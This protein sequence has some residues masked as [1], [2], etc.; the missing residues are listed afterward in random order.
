MYVN[1]VGYNSKYTQNVFNCDESDRVVKYFFRPNRSLK[2]GE[3]VELL[4]NY[5]DSY[6]RSR[7]RKGYGWRNLHEGL[8]GDCCLSQ[9]IQRNFVDRADVEEIIHAESSV[10]KLSTYINF[11]NDKVW[12]PLVNKIET[13]LSNSDCVGVLS[14]NEWTAAVRIQWLTNAFR[15]KVMKY[16]ACTTQDNLLNQL[17]IY[18]MTTT[19]DKIQSRAVD[20]NVFDE[21][22][23]LDDKGKSVKDAI[24]NELIEEVGFYLQKD[25]PMLLDSSVYCPVAVRL[26][27]K[28]SGIVSTSII[29]R[30]K[31]SDHLIKQFLKEQMWNDFLEVALVALNELCQAIENFDKDGSANYSDLVF[32][33][34]ILVKS[35]LIGPI[36]KALEL[37]KCSNAFFLDNTTVSKGF[38]A[39]L[40]DKIAYFEALQL[41]GIEPLIDTSAV[42]FQINEEI[43]MT[44]FTEISTHEE[45]RDLGSAP[46]SVSY[47]MKRSTHINSTWYTVW[48]IFWPVH[49]FAT[50]FLDS[51]VY[52]S[53]SFSERLG[54]SSEVSQ[55]ACKRGMRGGCNGELLYQS[56]IQQLLKSAHSFRAQTSFRAPT[57]LASELRKSTVAKRPRLPSKK[58]QATAQKTQH[59][60]AQKKQQATAQKKEQASSQK[61]QPATAQKKQQCDLVSPPSLVYEG[62]VLS[63]P[64]GFSSAGWTQKNFKRMSGESAGHIDRY[65]FTPSGNRLRSF[66]EILRYIA[67]LTA[68]NGDEDEAYRKRNGGKH[69]A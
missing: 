7:E 60:T 56:Q 57:S 31:T 65:W 26:I 9:R 32:S 49:A 17:L 59:A 50:K 14:L 20:V 48:Q 2:R 43:V 64:E 67:A 24:Q 33:S 11:L 22:K 54:I 46:R 41:S 52:S 28:L 27:K 25:L 15:Q 62:E 36:Q 47:A 34:G 10:Q 4:T 68:F 5:R 23:I 63:F 1:E 12:T 30:N 45:L 29:R 19:L 55:F 51:S 21:K 39:A 38:R 44:A 40:L 66:A 58:Q 35:S 6:E 3:T 69:S 8:Q 13:F 37:V 18:K 61:K 53:E 16:K 42:E